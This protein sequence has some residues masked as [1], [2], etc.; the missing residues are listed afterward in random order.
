M[1]QTIHAALHNRHTHAPGMKV[2]WKI[3]NC[4]SN[5]N[6]FHMHLLSLIIF[7]SVAIGLV[8][9]KGK[10]RDSMQWAGSFLA[11]RFVPIAQRGQ[12][13]VLDLLHMIKILFALRIIRVPMIISIAFIIIVSDCLM[14]TR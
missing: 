8:P 13:F 5:L 1:L 4:L 7:P 11:L 10:R 2:H 12:G 9:F 3:R 6:L 14:M